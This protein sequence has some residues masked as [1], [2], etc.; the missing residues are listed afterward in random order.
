MANS[1][2]NVATLRKFF[3]RKGGSS[4]AELAVTVSIMA[5]LTATASPKLAELSRNGKIKK[6]YDE[7]EKIIKQGQNF[8]QFTADTE[9]RGRFPGQEKYSMPVPMGSY[10]MISELYIENQENH[11]ET[12]IAVKSYIYEKINSTWT[13][14][15]PEL[16][17]WA[18]VFGT[19]NS[20]YSGGNIVN[21]VYNACETCD[22]SDPAYGTAGHEEWLKLFN[23][24]VLNSVY[25]DGHYIYLV[26]PGGETG[27]ETFPPI[28]IVADRDNVADL[29]MVLIP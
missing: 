6:S 1:V 24:E 21:D 28:L 18:S 20:W 5:T 14:N 7:M 17:N 29:N 8:Y 22:E 16:E 9:G 25:S 3:H 13:Y 19:E 15:H 4:L 11:R 27:E 2:K 26:I 10:G 12:I 23:G